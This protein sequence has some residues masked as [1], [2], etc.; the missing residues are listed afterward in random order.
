MDLL[1]GSDV[2]WGSLDS[3]ERGSVGYLLKTFFSQNPQHIGWFS[4]SLRLKRLQSVT[5]AE[6]RQVPPKN[7]WLPLVFVESVLG[8]FRYSTGEVVAWPTKS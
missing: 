4:M 3:W 7:L 6:S 1:I 2:I 5:R 8:S